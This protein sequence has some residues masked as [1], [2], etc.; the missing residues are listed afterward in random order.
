MDQIENIKI[1]FEGEADGNLYCLSSGKKTADDIKYDLLN[2][3]TIGKTWCEEFC[4]ASLNNPARFKQP[5]L[6]RKIKNFASA[7]VKSKITS[8]DNKIKVL[9]GTRESG[10][11]WT[12]SA[13]EY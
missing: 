13:P 1:P 9:Q 10:P 8:K 5:I 6:R 3:T 2:V 12:T 11:V 7:A 4:S